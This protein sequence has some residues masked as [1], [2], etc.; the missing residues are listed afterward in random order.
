[1]W[2]LSVAADKSLDIR[3]HCGAEYL[4]VSQMSLPLL[5]L[6]SEIV[7][8]IGMICFYLTGARNGEP[9]GGSLVCLDLSHSFLCPFGIIL[10]QSG[11]RTF[12]ARLCITSDF[13]E[14]Q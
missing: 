12:H 11:K 13:S 2:S 3:S 10:P 8:V 14:V 5:L 4:T 9:F 1:M 7:T 6:L